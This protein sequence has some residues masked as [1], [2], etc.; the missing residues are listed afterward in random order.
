MHYITNCGQFYLLD[1]KIFRSTFRGLFD[2][3]RLMIGR[4]AAIIVDIRCD[5]DTLGGLLLGIVA[6]GRWRRMHRCISAVTT[7]AAATTATTT[8]NMI[9]IVVTVIVVVVVYRRFL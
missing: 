2:G 3:V 1:T 4:L 8:T 9:I 6:N 7:S 5:I